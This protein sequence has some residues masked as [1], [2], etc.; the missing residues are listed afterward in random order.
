MTK[1]VGCTCLLTE[2]R[3]IHDPTCS[4]HMDAPEDKRVVIMICADPTNGQDEHRATG[5]QYQRCGG[6]R[7]VI[8]KR[9]GG[10]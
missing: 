2:K 6:G 3:W 1:P 4:V 9:I 8:R 10:N 7:R 5:V